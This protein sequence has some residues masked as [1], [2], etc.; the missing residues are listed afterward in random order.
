MQATEPQDPT[1]GAVAPTT[2]PT[3][4]ERARG[5]AGPDAIRRARAAVLA[6]FLI[7]GA[8]FA[9][10]VTRVPAIQDRYGLSDGALTLVLSL[11]PIIAGVGSAVAEKLVA[12]FGSAHVLWT[13]QPVVCVAAVGVGAGREVWELAAVLAVFGLALGAVDATMNMQAV[14]VQA[15]QGRSVM[16]GFYAAWSLGGMAGAGLAT[17]ADHK[18]VG[19]LVTYTISAAIT[20]PAAL[21]AGRHYLRTP[22]ADHPEPVADTAAGP[23]VPWRVLLPLCAVMT[24]IYLGDSAISSW[25]AVYAEKVQHADDNTALPYLVYMITALVGRSLG[26]LGVRRWGALPVVRVGA[27]T[28]A[29]GFAVVIAAPDQAVS[30]LGFTVLG[31]GLCTLVPLTFA[32]GAQTAPGN[33]DAAIA[34][35]NLFNYAGFL[36]GTPLIGAVGD[37]AGFRAAMAVP[38]LLVLGILPLARAFAP[39]GEARHD[40][41]RSA[42]SDR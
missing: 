15:V 41:D 32:A 39:Q 36:V 18:D 19:L 20:A 4:G 42:V 16:N 23:A 28:A 10:L 34:R 30:L 5:E 12:R 13:A 31:L 37:L 22:K 3:V 25:G 35:L 11:V 8:S 2:A 40:H 7:Q 29:V 33:P 14:G 26:D 1:E 6:A 38:L 9:A 21:L 24:F 27:L 17:L